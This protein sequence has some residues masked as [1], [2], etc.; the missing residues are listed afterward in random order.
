MICFSHR[1]TCGPPRP[2]VEQVEVG[3]RRECYIEARDTIATIDPSVPDLPALCNVVGPRSY[4]WQRA[5]LTCAKQRGSER[6]AK[7]CQNSQDFGKLTV[8]GS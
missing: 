8:V 3:M 7:Q 5:I 1:D 2:M 6:T 4:M